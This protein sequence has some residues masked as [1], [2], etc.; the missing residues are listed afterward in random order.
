MFA[1]RKYHA[2][3]FFTALVGLCIS[4]WSILL[5]YNKNQWPNM[6]LDKKTYIL[7]IHATQKNKI[8]TSKMLTFE[9]FQ[10]NRAS[11]IISRLL[12][13][14]TVL[15]LNGFYVVSQSK[16]VDFISQFP[17]SNAFLF[18]T[19]IFVAALWPSVSSCTGISPFLL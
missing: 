12:T 4:M 5:C 2:Q 16:W 17:P 10:M 6:E 7:N 8:S 13:K 19:H 11:S 1:A 9:G 15:S 18:S 3:G 14:Y